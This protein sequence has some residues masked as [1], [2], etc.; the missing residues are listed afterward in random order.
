MASNLAICI[1]R[2]EGSWLNLIFLY[3]L[4]Y[5][6]FYVFIFFI[7]YFPHLYMSSMNIQVLNK[8]LTELKKWTDGEQL[9]EASLSSHFGKH[10]PFTYSKYLLNPK[11]QNSELTKKSSLATENSVKQ[12]TKVWKDF[13]KPWGSCV[14][15]LHYQYVPMKEQSQ[16]PT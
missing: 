4:T 5:H 16:L 7:G 3:C 12:G 13:L 9:T 2:Y 14:S 8:Y 15:Q 10:F 11:H 6:M 1:L